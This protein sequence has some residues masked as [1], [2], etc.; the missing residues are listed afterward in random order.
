MQLLSRHARPAGVAHGRP[1]AG[2]PAPLARRAHLRVAAI[3][4][5]PVASLPPAQSNGSGASVPIAAAAV[6]SIA[7]PAVPAVA[8]APAEPLPGVFP[9]AAVY[10]KV[11][12]AGAAKAA[13][14]WAKVLVLGVLAGVY[15]GFGGLLA[16]MVGG[17]CPGAHPPG[18]GGRRG[19]L[20][21][22]ARGGRRRGGGG[23]RPFA[24][25]WPLRRSGA[26]TTSSRL[27]L[28]A[29]A[30]CCLPILNPL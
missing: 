1:R 17:N 14:P 2:L 16:N 18:G 9:P 8:P 5:P 20:G 12:E 13:M 21:G 3:A 6:P 24:L 7:L 4:E 30:E 27:G 29:P 19:A 15:I 25:P 23:R 22:M 28:W 26:A 11:V 10:S